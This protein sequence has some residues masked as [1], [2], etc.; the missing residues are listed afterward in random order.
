MNPNLPV[1]SA[2]PFFLALLGIAIVKIR[3]MDVETKK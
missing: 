1:S 3:R 2:L